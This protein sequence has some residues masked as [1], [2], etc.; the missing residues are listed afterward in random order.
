MAPL[1]HPAKSPC[2]G[3]AGF[4]TR[5]LYFVFLLSLLPR[6]NALH[7]MK[8]DP[9]AWVAPRA[10]TVPLVISNQCKE[11]IYPG[12][13]TQ[14]GTSPGTRGFG[15]SP[16]SSRNLT[17]GHD[18]QGRVWGRTN[19]SFNFD[20]TGPSNTGGNNGGGSAC[21]TGDCFGVVECQVAGAPPATL[22]EF[23]LATS[24]GQTFYDISL[25]DGYNI[26]IGIVSLYPESGNKSLTEIPPNLTNPICIGTA[27][28]LA[29][30]GDTSD[31]N[32]GTNSSFPIP[33]EESLSNDFVQSWCPWDLQLDAPSKPGDGVYPYP[34]DTIQRPLFDPCYSAC[35]KNHK[36]SDC[37]VGHYDNPSVCKPSEYSSQAKKVCPDAYSYAFDDQ[38]STFIIPSGGG[39]EVV[40]CPSGRSSNILN[41]LGNELR[42]LAATGAVPP[43]VLAELQNITFIRSRNAGSTAAEEPAWLK[44]ILALLVVSAV[45]L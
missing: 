45:M 44:A 18:W 5:I 40:F 17:V 21:S 34:D 31:A 13:A 30:K 3:R 22:A 43:Q 4:A 16:G 27:A 19:C 36:D 25:V 10:N 9:I 7:H 29:A 6:T 35:A 24:S 39:F 26:P 12:I 42:Q 2:A 1:Y 33:L 28:L 8:R 37:C 41:T 32:L 14:S 11:T 23:T 20:G 38:T 15:L